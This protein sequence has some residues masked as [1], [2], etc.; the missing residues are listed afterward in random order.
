[1]K[2]L[3]IG[4]GA[5]E[6]ALVSALSRDDGVEAVIAAPGNPG[7][8]LLCETRPVDQTDPEAC[9]A[10]ARELDV[11]L[12]VIGPEAPLVAGVADALRAASF[13]VFGP[14]Q[15]AATLE[16]SKAYAKEVMEAAGVPTAAAVAATTPAEARAALERFG[17]PHVVKADGLAA[18]KGVVVTDDFDEA[19]AH[20]ES[21]LSAS[22]RVVIEEYL[23]GPE[24]SLFAVCDGTVA[25]P[26]SPAQDFK[27]IG[28][29]DTGPNTGGM[30]A[31][32][33]LPWAPAGMVDEIVSRVAQPVVDELARRGS[34]FAGLLYCGLALTS[35]GL[36]VIEFNV[37]FGDPETQSVLARL[38]TPLAGLLLAAAQ[39]TLAEQPPLDWDPRSAVTVVLAAANYPEAPQ[40]GDPIAG[41]E[42][43]LALEGVDVLHAGTKLSSEGEFLTDGGRVL[44]VVAL[45]EGLA[46]ARAK[47]YE[48]A[49]LISWDGMQL[50]SD[51]ALRAERGEIEVP[52]AS[53]GASSAGTNAAAAVARASAEAPALPGWKH[54]YSGKVRDLY[55]RA[56][57][58]DLASAD[59]VLMVASDR[60]SAYDWVLSTEIPDKGK[61]LTGLSVWWFDQLSDLV[62]SHVVSVD[63][64][65]EVAGRALICRRLDMFEVECVARGFLTGSGLADYRRTGAVCGN[66]LPAGLG[67]GSRLEPAIFTPATK[68]AVGDHDE[69][70]DF[71]RTVELLGQ[72]DA[73]ALRDLTL[74]VYER[75]RELAGERGIVLADTKFEFGRDASGAIVLGD[76]VLTPD[77]SRFWD[78]ATFVPGEAAESFD[79]QFVRDW[80]TSPESGWD[81][82]G[83][84]PP[85]EL[86]A[87]VVERTRA[88]YLEAF[89]RITGQPFPG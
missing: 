3:V 43:A 12:V 82:S 39:G 37:R 73:E 6:H 16:G 8:D 63:V 57:A 21:C 62:G 78:A 84:V 19:V 46:E 48:A 69:N 52:E 79:K 50:R 77:S 58:V 88:R 55:I 60:I 34:P 65:A 31:Y 13:P 89:E 76:E 74:R 27:R 38:R 9:V 4:P 22:D 18:G 5:R 35:R 71:G 59:E 80:L 61:V 20:A 33:P 87:E 10:L 67:E 81:K 64:P 23:D 40:K 51:I 86:P 41:L 7:I 56:G 53:A 29:G 83:T 24:V 30:G 26:L 72:E 45:G 68:A 14:G 47:A 17:A 36:R 25:V 70:I 44:S 66:E 1:M 54:A 11:S 42:E 2:V 75:A 15:E 49:S 85:P 32:S 28:D